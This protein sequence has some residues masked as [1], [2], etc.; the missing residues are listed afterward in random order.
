MPDVDAAVAVEIDAV[1]VEFRRQELREAGGAG[2]G[3]AHVLACHHAVADHLQR[4]DELGAILIL[5]PAD[6]GLRRQHAQSVIGQRVAAVIGFAA[7]DRKHDGCGHAE[8]R[9]DCGERG[10]IFL[11]QPLPFRRQPRDAGFFQIIGRH[12]HELGLRRRAGRGTTG[13]DQIGQFVVGLETAGLGIERR[14]R[15]A[16][17]LR[18]RPQRGDELREAGVSGEG[19]MREQHEGRDERNGT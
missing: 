18:L 12:L 8:A 9:L 3:R 11:Q 17:R 13:Q 7:P 5:A 2:P 19:R 6:I 14:A 15:H 16:G 10:A 4:Q 1:L